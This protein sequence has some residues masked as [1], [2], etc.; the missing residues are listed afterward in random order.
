[1]ATPAEV[2]ATITVIV[3]TSP[4]SRRRSCAS[5]APAGLGVA[6]AQLR[7]RLAV[8]PTFVARPADD[9]ASI[10]PRSPTPTIR[11]SP[12]RISSRSD[13]S[14]AKDGSSA[15]R[16]GETMDA[17]LCFLGRGRIRRTLTIPSS[18]P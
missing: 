8:P 10:S 2:S 6:R 3:A 1:M 13:P 17:A 15:W 18:P 12:S 5:A 4:H 9:A 7:G 16:S 11:F 14:D